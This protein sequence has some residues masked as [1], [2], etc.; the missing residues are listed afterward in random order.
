MKINITG[1]DV[2]RGLDVCGGDLSIYLYS[3]GI[4]VSSMPAFL[5]KLRSVSKETKFSSEI[6][7]EYVINVHSLKSTSEYVGALEAKDTAKKLE[8]MAR[9]GNTAGILAQNERYIEYLEKLLS[10]IQSWLKENHE[11]VKDHKMAG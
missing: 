1:L 9:E 8:V 3:L 4:Y 11:F 2:E 10:D 6:L 7:H 5:A